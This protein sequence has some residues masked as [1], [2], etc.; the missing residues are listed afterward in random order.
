VTDRALGELGEVA[1]VDDGLAIRRDLEGLV[2]PI[3]PEVPRLLEEADVLLKRN[4]DRTLTH[5]ADI[6]VPVL[7]A[8]ARLGHD[9]GKDEAGL[10]AEDF[11]RDLCAAFH[12]VNCRQL[13]KIGSIVARAR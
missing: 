7:P 2:A 12:Q 5:A 10:L 8:I 9:V 11:L 4:R 13:K 3:V 6:V 1:A